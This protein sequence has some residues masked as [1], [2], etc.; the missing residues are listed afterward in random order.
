MRRT[1]TVEWYGEPLG[2]EADVTTAEYAGGRDVEVD[3]VSIEGMSTAALNA[4]SDEGR[5]YIRESILD[6]LAEEA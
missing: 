5:D 4:M 2:V 3:I 1:F 6:I